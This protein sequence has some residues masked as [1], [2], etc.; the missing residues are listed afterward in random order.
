MR[1][2]EH[3]GLEAVHASAVIPS[4]HCGPRDE[5]EDEPDGGQHDAPGEEL[6]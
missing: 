5:P 4:G 2:L 6:E 3:I 1:E